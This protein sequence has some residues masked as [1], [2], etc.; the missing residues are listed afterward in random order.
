MMNEATE[1][2]DMNVHQVKFMTLKNS[3]VLAYVHLEK[4]LSKIFTYI[5][6]VY[7]VALI[8]TLIPQA[9]KC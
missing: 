1:R 2:N 6:L 9:H 5:I 4:S 3:L 7:D 8:T